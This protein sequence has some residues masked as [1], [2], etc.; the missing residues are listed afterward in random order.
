MTNLLVTTGSGEHHVNLCAGQS[1]REALDATDWRVRAAC[2][3][4]G[5]C[6][7]C[8][9]IRLEGAANPFTLAEYQKL[10]GEQ[11]AQ[12][13]RLACQLRPRGDCRIRLDHPAPP[14]PWRSIPAEDLLDP[15]AF[16][17]ALEGPIYGIAVDLGTT[18]IRVAL[19]DRKR[20]RRIAAR[21]GPNPQ[22]AYGADV[23]NRLSRAVADPAC[24]RT[25]A[26]LAR[27]AVMQAVHDM[28]VRDVGE[29]HAMPAEIG[30]VMVVGNTAML[31]LLTG[32]GAA[33]LLDPANWQ[34]PVDCRPPDAAV[35]QALW[36][37]PN[38]AVRVADAVAGFVGSDLV[39]DLIATRLTESQAGALL[40]DV[41]TNTELALWDGRT[42]HVT[43]VPGGPA[44]EGGG[45][46]HGMAAETGAIFRVRWEDGIVCEVIGGGPALGWCGSGLVDAIA[47]LLE[48]G[49]LQPSGRYA[50]SPGVAGYALLPDNPL[51]VLGG[52]DIDAFQRAK[53]ATAAAMATLL[54]LAGMAWGD[55]RRVCV[56]GAF[57]RRLDIGHA[58]RVG[59]LPG[60]NPAGIE[61][62][63]GAALAGCERALLT[64]HGEQLFAAETAKIRLVNLACV[65]GYEDRYIDHLRLAPMPLT[66]N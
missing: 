21:S 44:F 29:A 56:C 27:D 25:M 28:L 51:T 50:Q 46:R 10:T 48:T 45:I 11:R 3:G 9:V 22:R 65:Q 36:P 26:E 33:T 35:W 6:G 38:A 37:L 61:L 39:A 16:L 34:H 52:S 59:L 43:S 7:A 54:D 23:L 24:A 4:I 42:L 60:L 14:S 5:A 66:S 62:Y 55:I 40:L 13:W 64:A 2:G 31:A 32:H 53:A 58:Q 57:G 18:C 19:W 15:A 30:Q 17:P 49:I 63:A 47:V 41:G 1:V 20:G 8:A 12:G